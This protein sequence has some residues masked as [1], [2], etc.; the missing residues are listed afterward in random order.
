MDRIAMW[1]GCL[2]YLQPVLTGLMGHRQAS[3]TFKSTK[4][5]QKLSKLVLKKQTYL[6]SYEP[7]FWTD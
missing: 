2:L 5:Y 7:R 6:I 1:G 3:G 4:L